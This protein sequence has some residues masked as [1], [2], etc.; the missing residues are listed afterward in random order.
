MGNDQSTAR[1]NWLDYIDIATKLV[2]GLILAV[3]TFFINT[4]NDL[5]K[6]NNDLKQQ[7][8]NNNLK[9]GDFTKSLM[10][11]L[12]ARD[13]AGYLH[14][15][16][17]L[18]VL[19]RTV[20]DQDPKLIASIGYC[21]VSDYVQNNAKNAN[22]T[23]MQTILSIIKERDTATYNKINALWASTNSD[24]HVIDES[25]VKINAA[26][27]K[28]LDTNIVSLI[29]EDK[30]DKLTLFSSKA[31]VFMQINNSV[32][33]T[34]NKALKCLDM[35]KNAGFITPGIE[36][37]TS[38]RFPDRIKYFYDEDL[39]FAEKIQAKIYASFKDSIVLEK[40]NNPKARQGIIEIWWNPNAAKPKKRK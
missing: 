27:K 35:L 14:R 6:R 1:N 32:D 5:Q 15:D 22:K 16:I 7:E 4:N 25:S 20:G 11:E 24:K 37:I 18:I 2:V 10:Q 38:F 28:N 3:A 30:L 29:S 8:I 21:L 33:S 19:D 26:V 31:T 9:D 36:T 13:T 34:K 39:K 12:V 17:A 23:T 40:Q